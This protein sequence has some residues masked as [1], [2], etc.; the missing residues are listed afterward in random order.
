M[1]EIAEVTPGRAER[2]AVEAVAGSVTPVP[3]VH[4]PPGHLREDAVYATDSGNGTFLAAEHLRLTYPNRAHRAGGLLVHGILGAGGGRGRPG[5]PGPGRGA[6]PGDGAFLMTGMEAL[7]ATAYRAAPLVCVLRDGKLGQIAQFQK[8]P[9][10][11]ETCSELPDYS[12]EGMAVGRGGPL[13][14]AVS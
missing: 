1:R 14:P 7:T 3:P 5:L 9:L 4:L 12:V 13:L 6:L 2:W 11:R 10:N 8:T